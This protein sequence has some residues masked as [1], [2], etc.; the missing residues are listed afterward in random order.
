MHFRSGLPAAY[1]AGRQ[2]LR[3]ADTTALP[4]AANHVS[5][6]REA[7]ERVMDVCG[8]NDA[9]LLLVL[10]LAF[11]ARATTNPFIGISRALT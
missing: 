7:L 11:R 4:P 8:P 5:L 3:L 1:H 10:L 9:P 6:L 2:M